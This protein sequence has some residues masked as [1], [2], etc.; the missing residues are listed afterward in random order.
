MCCAATGASS[1]SKWGSHD[2][3]LPDR[4]TAARGG[5]VNNWL[6]ANRVD[7]A[8]EGVARDCHSGEVHHWLRHCE[9]DRRLDLGDPG[10]V[11]G[12]LEIQDDIVGYGD[13]PRGGWP[14]SFAFGGSHSCPPFRRCW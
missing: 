1:C 2:S 12:D 7:H 13:D 4:M 5:G 6:A 14:T 11:V 10:R 8:P 3:T 9:C